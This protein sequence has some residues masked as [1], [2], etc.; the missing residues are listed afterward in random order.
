MGD[1]T[2]TDEK[3]RILQEQIAQLT[4]LRR[5][6][7]LRLKEP[8]AYDGVKDAMIIDDWF[9][10]IENHQEFYQW[11]EQRT[12]LFS[13][14]FI[15]GRALQWHR[16]LKKSEDPPT[17]WQ[18][19]KNLI[20]N[21]FRPDNADLLARDRL[22]ATKQTTTIESYVESFTDVCILLENLTEDEKCDRFM[23]GLI[24][25]E[26]RA[27]LRNIPRAQ[28]TLE[29]YFSTA[30]SYEA[31]RNPRSQVLA[32]HLASQSH[33]H[34]AIT[35]KPSV[36]EANDP[37]EIDMIENHRRTYKNNDRNKSYNNKSSYG[38]NRRPNNDIR[39][40]YCQ[41]VGHMKKDC[42]EFNNVSR[43]ERE[44]LRKIRNK[45]LHVIE[46]INGSIDS[47]SNNNSNNKDMN[48]TRYLVKSSGTVS[49]IN[50]D[51]LHI[52]EELHSASA[53]DTVLPLYEATVEPKEDITTNSNMSINVLVDTGASECYISSRIA[54]QIKGNCEKVERVVE[55]AGGVTD[56]ISEQ[57]TFNLN[58]QGYI[59]TIRAYIYDSKF[60]VILGRTWL[61]IS[62]TVD[63][64]ER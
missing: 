12:Y 55:T 32:R 6:P 42:Q 17:E 41:A 34:T 49:N 48:S 61:K 15:T 29:F 63:T 16:Q 27:I 7:V 10:A 54:N 59:S 22:V 43:T 2:T 53:K 4:L 23:R 47:N 24:S 20:S 14:S 39:C 64:M 9:T 51:I 1:S 18:V 36:T 46:N 50:K 45:E 26:I 35:E 44:L 31:A 13:I 40:Y 11:D 30:L 58:L 5:E 28:R 57:F 8:P 62:R 25:D 19:F 56:K 21:K 33:T 52:K 37:M 3:I 38:R 60:D